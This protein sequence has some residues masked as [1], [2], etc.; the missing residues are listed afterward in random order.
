[1]NQTDSRSVEESEQPR[2]DDSLNKL[3]VK[4]ERNQMLRDSGLRR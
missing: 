2:T 3:G 1:M 4:R